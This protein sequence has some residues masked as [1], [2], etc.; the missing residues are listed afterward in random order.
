MVT[1]GRREVIKESAGI[2][3]FR[4]RKRELEV[5]LAHPGGP[6]WANR[7]LGAWS[8]P[9]GE[10]TEAEDPLEAARREFEEETGFSAAG[11]FLPLTPLRQSSAKRVS[12]WALEG[13]CVPSRARSNNFCLEWPPKSGEYQEFPEIDRVEWF[14]LASA[15][16]KLVKGQQAFLDEL[17]ERLGGK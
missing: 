2:L 8:I 5:L 12:A 15:R 7:D 17:A 13:D 1:N 10:F 4:R 11:E 3:L 9:K 6:Y 14:N 16:A